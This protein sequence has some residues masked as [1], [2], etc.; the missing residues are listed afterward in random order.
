M[1]CETDL[2]SQFHEAA[3]ALDPATPPIQVLRQNQ[4][5]IPHL[6]RDKVQKVVS[7]GKPV[8]FVLDNV[9]EVEGK[10]PPLDTYCP[11]RGLA[12]VLITSRQRDRKST[13]LNS[14]HLGIS[15]AVFCLK[16]K[17]K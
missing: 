16:K 3:Q 5:N 6:L 15:Y 9:P 4:V 10:L 11:A 13:R 17:K 2:E 1:Q 7:Q 12:A 8:L 14:S